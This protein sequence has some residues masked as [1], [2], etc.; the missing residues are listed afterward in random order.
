MKLLL[1]SKEKFLIKKGY[2]LLDIPRDKLRIGYITTALKVV[3]DLEYLA[4]MKEYVREMTE[5]GIN[6]TEFDI[7][8]KSEK[9]I[10]DFF[11]D[12]NVIQV[13]G[14]NLFYLL[15]TIRK[16][17]FDVILRDLL[18]KGL[19]YVGCSAGTYIL[20]PTVEVG[21]WKASR[22]RYGI[23]DFTGLSYVPF[24]IKCHYTDDMKEKVLE[25]SKDL[26]Y[27]LRILRDD[28]AFLIKDSICSFIGD[29]EVKI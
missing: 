29:S 9:E 14:G 11:A 22:N 28:Q 13:S 5:A 27:P 2:D 7:E 4:Y 17:G 24:L 6:F 15:G 8:D 23:T 1:A 25:K 19:W 21:G 26:Q 12:K 18:D 3:D 16:S 20:C 10:R